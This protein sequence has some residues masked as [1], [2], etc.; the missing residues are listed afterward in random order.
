[1]F[2]KPRWPSNNLIGAA[3][4]RRCAILPSDRQDRLSFSIS[5]S[6]PKGLRRKFF[7]TFCSNARP[8]YDAVRP[9]NSD[10]LEGGRTM[11]NPG[12]LL[13]PLPTLN[14][15]TNVEK[16]DAG[17]RNLNHCELLLQKFW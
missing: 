14:V 10:T 12:S 4:A 15:V 3:S 8:L 9:M 11:S 2:R 13:E 1:M 17:L 7:L 6:P 16:L 5:L